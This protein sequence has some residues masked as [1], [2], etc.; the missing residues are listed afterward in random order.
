[1]SHST[2]Y[3]I[4]AIILHT[5]MKIDFYLFTFVFN[6]FLILFF[7]WVFLNLTSFC[8]NVNFFLFNFKLLTY[9]QLFLETEFFTFLESLIENFFFHLQEAHLFKIF[10][11]YGL[12]MHIVIGIE[13]S[14]I[15][16]FLLCRICSVEGYLEM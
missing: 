13:Q 11:I 16:Y 4:S 14:N 10:K 6:T 2:L 12:W 8:I 7:I 1:M 3:L 9:S 5:E 15:M